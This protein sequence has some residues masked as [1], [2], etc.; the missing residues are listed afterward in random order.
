[1]GAASDYGESMSTVAPGGDRK[2]VSPA[3]L[4]DVQVNDFLLI[5]VGYALGMIREE[6]AERNLRLFVE[7]GLTA[8][9]SA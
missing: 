8:G 9:D 1:M 5:H 2:E 6:K 3:R 4:D 7:A